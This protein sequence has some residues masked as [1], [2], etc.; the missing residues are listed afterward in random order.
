MLAAHFT[1]SSMK[2]TAHEIMCLIF[3][4][5]SRQNAKQEL[6]RKKGLYA[7]GRFL[8]MSIISAPMITITAIIAITAGKK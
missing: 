3:I 5:F 6:K 2:D 8:S 7:Y 4:N 1:D